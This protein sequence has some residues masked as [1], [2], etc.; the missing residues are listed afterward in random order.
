MMSDE[1]T[2]TAERFVTVHSPLITHYVAK[3]RTSWQHDPAGAG[4]HHHA[5]AQR[6]APARPAEHHARETDGGSFHR[7][8]FRDDYGDSGPADRRAQRP[9]PFGGPDAHPPHQIPEH[10]PGAVSEIP[11]RRRREARNRNSRPDPKSRRRKRGIGP[12]ARPGRP[13]GPARSSAVA[14]GRN[15]I[16]HTS[17]AC[18][19][20]GNEVVAVSRA[21]RPCGWCGSRGNAISQTQ[22]TTHGRDARDTTRLFGDRI[23]S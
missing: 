21:S 10:P 3:N 15:M 20:H 6:P 11:H 12:Q 8:R 14:G 13:G 1:Y 5:R 16:R 9:A 19:D 17:A 23:Q 22:Y 2:V 7:G 18:T 4:G